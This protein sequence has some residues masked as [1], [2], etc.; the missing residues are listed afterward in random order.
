MSVSCQRSYTVT[1]QSNM[2]LYWTFDTVAAGNY[3]DSSQGV[4][5]VPTAAPTVTGKI[6]N[7]VQLVGA[8]SSLL[9]ADFILGGPNA[10]ES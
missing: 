2:L 10:A 4:L 3:V 9:D 6:G 1:V 7:G 8:G 5:F